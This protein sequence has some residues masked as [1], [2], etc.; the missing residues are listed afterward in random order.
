MGDATKILLSTLVLFVASA[1]EGGFNVGKMNYGGRTMNYYE[2]EEIPIK[3]SDHDPNGCDKDCEIVLQYMCYDPIDRQDTSNGK[4]K[5]KG[6]SVLQQSGSA[7]PI[8]AV[9]NR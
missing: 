7:E 2:G 3:W 1:E 6:A 4:G 5:G 9:S 8:E